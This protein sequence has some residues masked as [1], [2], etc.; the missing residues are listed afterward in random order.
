[1]LYLLLSVASTTLLFFIFKLFQKYNIPT[2]QAIVVNYVTCILVGLAFPGGTAVLHPQV[3]TQSWAIFAFALG[4]IFI[5]TFYLM[6][7]TT[8]KVGVTATS[9]ATKISLIIPV[10]FSLLVLKSSLKEYTWV[11]YAGMAA[12]IAAIILSSIRLS[13]SN[14]SIRTPAAAAMALPFIIFLTSGIA[15]S[16]IN[17]TNQYHLQAGEASQFTMLT[18]TT[19][20]TVGL[21]VLAYFILAGKTRFIPRSI[22]AGVLLGVPNYFSIFFLIKA[23]SAFNNDGA[24]L[25][26]INNIGIILAGAAGAVIFFREKLSTVNLV[27]IGMAVL[28][29]ILISYQEITANLF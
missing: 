23:L 13:N 26:P 12:A 14:S 28:A 8:H 10:L 20:A 27:G 22:I 25:Y 18:F 3:F 17:Y 2:F 21:L 9:V 24:F 6:A 4:I 15:D 29:L 11:N 7:L 1:M 5:G 19:S 16:L